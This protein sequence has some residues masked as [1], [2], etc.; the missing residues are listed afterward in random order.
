MTVELDVCPTGLLNSNLEIA[1][2]S[3]V[4]CARNKQVGFEFC[5]SLELVNAKP[6]RAQGQ[7]QC[8]VSLLNLAEHFFRG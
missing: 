4:H 6:A 8:G 2:A 5:V 1:T 7:P 3:L